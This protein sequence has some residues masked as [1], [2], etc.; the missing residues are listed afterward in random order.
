MALSLAEAS[1]VAVSLACLACAALPIFGEAL[2]RINPVSLPLTEVSGSFPMVAITEVT[3]PFL[4]GGPTLD[5]SPVSLG[6]NPTSRGGN[7]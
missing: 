6:V 7:H 4:S 2:H 3:R 1:D 5:R